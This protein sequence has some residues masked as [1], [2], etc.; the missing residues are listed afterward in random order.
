MNAHIDMVNEPRSSPQPLDGVVVAVLSARRLLAAL[1]S[2][3]IVFS[4]GA[5]V[6]LVPAAAGDDARVPARPL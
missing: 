3:L 1:G 2:V 6:V 4:L 5:S